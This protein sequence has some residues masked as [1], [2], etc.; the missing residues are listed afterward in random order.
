[1]AV[2]GEKVMH[3]AIQI[4]D[5]IVMLS[6]GQCKG[7]AEFKGISL[8]ISANNDADAERLFKGLAEGG[9]VIM[10]LG[11]SFFAS[12]F[13]MIADRFGVSWMVVSGLQ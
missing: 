7:P 4:G 8:S 5:T 1:M 10:P 12:R 11:P 2:P 13:G 3:A 6:D 9:R